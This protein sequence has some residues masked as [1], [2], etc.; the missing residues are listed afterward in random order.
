MGATHQASP[1]SGACENSL[2]SAAV[3]PA[4]TFLFAV[5]ITLLSVLCPART[6]HGLTPMA[7]QSRLER[8]AE[9][10]RW[11]GTPSSRY[12]P[13]GPGK[14]S[15]GC[16]FHNVR[17]CLSHNIGTAVRTSVTPSVVPVSRGPHDAGSCELVSGYVQAPLGS[18]F[19]AGHGPHPLRVGLAQKTLCDIQSNAAHARDR[20]GPAVTA[21]SRTASH[22]IQSTLC[23]SRCCCIQGSSP[24]LRQTYHIQHTRVVPAVTYSLGYSTTG[25]RLPHTSNPVHT[26]V[27]PLNLPGLSD[28]PPV[29]LSTVFK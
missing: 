23:L 9:A 21:D 6:R 24:G 22:A 25:L 10:K 7:V 5:Q 17:L 14:H 27:G 8:S 2:A 15:R 3:Q 12:H 26:G 4:N 20:P 18:D 29:H 28:T 13:L 11:I 16:P 1:R 19:G